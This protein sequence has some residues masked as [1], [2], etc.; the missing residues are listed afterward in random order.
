MS[1]HSSIRWHLL[2]ALR[3]FTLISMIIFHLLYDI[4]I[5]YGRFP[6]WLDGSLPNIWQQC[7]CCTFII[8]SG[9]VF[10]FSRSHWK[11]GLIINAWGFGISLSTLLVL[12]EETIWF[13]ILNMIGSAILLTALLQP[14]LEKI[15]WKTGLI[16]SIF[17][18]L[19]CQ[20]IPQG[21]LGCYNFRFYK[22][23]EQWYCWFPGAWLGFPPVGFVSSDYFPLIPW[24]FVFWIG[25]YLFQVLQKPS[26]KQ[27][28]SQNPF[29]FLSWTGRKTLWIYLLH[30]PALMLLCIIIFHGQASMNN[31]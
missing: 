17:L 27:I 20:Q 23:P 18:F 15:P 7:I 2:D 11:R 13:G 9:V 25:Y 21:F 10:H 1:D 19:V 26:L 16:S 12:P 5:I 3:G 8:I 4:F 24:L 30:Q 14:F 22:L 6:S 29:P 28:L 31:L